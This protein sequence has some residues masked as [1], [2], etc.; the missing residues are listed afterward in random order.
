MRASLTKPG[1]TQLTLADGIAPNLDLFPNLFQSGEFR[2]QDKTVSR[3]GDFFAQIDVL[4]ARLNKSRSWIKSVGYSTNFLQDS[5]T[6]RQSLVTG[7]GLVTPE[8][9]Q[10]NYG[11]PVGQA[12]LGFTGAFTT[13]FALNAATGSKTY[14]LTFAANGG[15]VGDPQTLFSVNDQIIFTAPLAQAC[16]GYVVSTPSAT[17]MII[18]VPGAQPTAVGATQGM[19]FTV[20]PFLGAPSRRVGSFEMIW[21]PPLSIFKINHGLPN[22]RYELVL[23]P[24]NSQVFQKLAIQS[25]TD[26][27]AGTDFKFEVVDMFLY[28][29]TVEGPRADDLTYLLDL[30]ESR[31]QTIDLN[32]DALQQKNFDVSPSTYALTACLQDKRAGTVTQFPLTRFKV[33]A[34]GDQ[35]DQDKGLGLNRMY[36]NYAGENKPSPDA[37][38]LFAPSVNPRVDYTIQRYNESLVNSGAFFDTG[39]AETIE[40]FHNNG[41]YYYF[42]WPRDGSDRSTRV[43]V[44]MGFVNATGITSANTNLLLFDHSRAVARVVIAGG[45]VRS[46][47]YETA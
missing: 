10:S 14:L 17:T 20:A 46:V 33:D 43:N 39:G 4:E 47:D 40:E 36:I 34:V 5:F 3:I 7:D 42:A 11:A 9:P 31:C 27:I 6:A 28:V 25:L 12:V 13:S 26:K 19:V 8:Q 32:G 1:G 30:E 21:T 22:G 41:S 35:V 45:S 18:N 29:C 16:V 24:Q 38:P 15:A 44:N 23:N 37:D 2:I